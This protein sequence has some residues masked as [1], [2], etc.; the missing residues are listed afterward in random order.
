VRLSGD[1]VVQVDQRTSEAAEISPGDSVE[2]SLSGAPVLLAEP[3][4]ATPAA[5]TPPGHA[6]AS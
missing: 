4:G 3:N 2:V 1:V 6:P 5:V